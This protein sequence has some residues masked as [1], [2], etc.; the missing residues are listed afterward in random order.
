MCSLNLA[1]AK[2]FT[3]AFSVYLMT[4][5]AQPTT[6]EAG[7]QIRP[8]AARLEES[9]RDLVHEEMGIVRDSAQKK[10]TPSGKD[11]FWLFLCVADAAL[12]LWLLPDAMLANKRMELV[13]KLLT[14]LGGS[15]FVLGYVWFR[16]LFLSFVRHRGF[17][18][19]LITLPFFLVPL[20]VT[21][22][23]IFPGAPVVEPKNA[24]LE[25]DGLPRQ[26]ENLKLSLA[27]HTVIVRESGKYG[28]A[29][30]NERE[31]K[32]GP[33]VVWDRWWNDKKFYWP[34]FYKVPVDFNLEGPEKIEL[35][36]ND[37][38]FDP[39]FRSSKPQLTVEGEGGEITNKDGTWR[40]DNSIVF[41]WPYSSGT[42]GSV[43]VTL[44]YGKY[45]LTATYSDKDKC[46]KG[47]VKSIMARPGVEAEVISVERKCNQ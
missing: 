37:G 18:I 4:D 35:V 10:Q 45:L 13:G 19:T 12:L 21:Q 6:Q 39:E 17:K 3:H 31:F 27:N 26:K 47:A 46:D 2:T 1:G 8:P 42:E 28:E 30:G 5:P 44:P 9:L 43:A 24:D 36:K 7:E 11:A 34:L 22:M 29:T 40:D 23:D 32:F 15:L 41:D 38:R 25:I 20:Y 14:W 33:K 16:K